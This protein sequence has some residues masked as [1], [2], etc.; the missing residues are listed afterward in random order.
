M[1]DLVA[2]VT[3]LERTLARFLAQTERGIVR[4]ADNVSNPPTDAELNTAF[5]NAA[6]LPEGFVGIVDD[7]GAGIAVWLCIQ[8]NND[9]HTL[10]AGTGGGPYV[11]KAGDTMTGALVIDPASGITTGALRIDA[12]ASSTTTYI[13]KLTQVGVDIFTVRDDNRIYSASPINFEI[14]MGPRSNSSGAEMRFPAGTTT[15]GNIEIATDLSNGTIK[16]IEFLTAIG[17]GCIWSY[18]GIDGTAQ[19]VKA[20]GTDD[21]L[22]YLTGQFVIRDSA[23]NVAAGSVTPI[24]PSGT[25]NLYD[26]GGTNT[27]QLQI[28]ANGEITVQR[29]AGS[30]TYK[31]VLKLI[32]I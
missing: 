5:G 26:D 25:F 1:S 17:N 11:L 12:P 15:G 3:K 16:A 29:T 10:G 23:G 24:A 9:W 14:G 22:Y 2:R 31:V 6:D 21:V 4:R 30:R 19:I 18:D 27:C 20:N 8:S 32:W 28:A 7:S 13:L